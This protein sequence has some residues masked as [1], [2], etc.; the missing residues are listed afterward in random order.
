L[1]VCLLGNKTSKHVRDGI[2]SKLNV[3][4]ACYCSVLKIL[5]RLISK[6]LKA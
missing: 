3:G 6:M 4:I 1:F 5:F 2:R